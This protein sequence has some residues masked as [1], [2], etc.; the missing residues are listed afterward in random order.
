M[1][2]TLSLAISLL[3]VLGGLQFELSSFN[4]AIAASATK[5]EQRS[6]KTM[7]MFKQ[8]VPAANDI[9]ARAKGILVMPAIYQGGI[10]V[11]GKYGEGA[12]KINGKT[13]DYYNM[14]GASYGL[15]LGGQKKSLVIAFMDD[16]SLQE[17]QSSNGF[18]FGVD[19]TAAV[20]TVGAD[21]R[22]NVTDL[23]KPIL[24]F[25]VDQ[26]GLMYNLSLA[27]SKFTKINR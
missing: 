1:K 23:N 14:I 11:G 24:A 4:Q 25:A 5:I 20:I 8:K 21:G 18:E 22:L 6:T 17:F 12:L 15:Q 10:G 2:K 7:A 13:V 27:G 9:L 26:K 3:L 19:A 16:H